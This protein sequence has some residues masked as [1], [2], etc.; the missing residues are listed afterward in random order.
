MEY[1]IK[2]KI[3]LTVN[4]FF[5]FYHSQRLVLCLGNHSELCVHAKILS[6]GEAIL[7]PPKNRPFFLNRH[8]CN[9]VHYTNLNCDS[10]FN[11]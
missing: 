4:S 9:I 2:I 7:S 11:Q 6:N 5:P 8:I 3:I 10:T 1:Y